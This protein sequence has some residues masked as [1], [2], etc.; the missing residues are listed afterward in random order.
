ME[1]NGKVSIMHKADSAPAT[2]G[3]L[4][5]KV[6]DSFLPITLISEGKLM[7]ENLNLAK[8]DQSQVEKIVKNNGGK[9]IKDVL[10]LT[11]DQM[12]ASYI[13]LMQGEGKSFQSK[14]V[15]A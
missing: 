5:L 15:G 3:D 13:Q 7:V 6:E 12:G 1:T 2:N 10:L 14:E 11:I 8:L 9:S 4:K